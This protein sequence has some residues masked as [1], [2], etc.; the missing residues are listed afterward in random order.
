MTFEDQPDAIRHR[1]WL[2]TDRA[3]RL[4]AERLIKIRTNAEVKVA[5]KDSS[6][7]FSH[8]QPVMHGDPVTHLKFAADQWAA[9]VRKLSQR[10]N[11]YPGI[12]TSSV[13]VSYLEETKYFVDTGG[14]ACATDGDL[15]GW[16]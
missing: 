1:I 10:F 4:A 15:P 14:T 8:E 2:D 9:R 12:L 7:D 11:D 5:E 3:Y 6:S 13:S 16:W